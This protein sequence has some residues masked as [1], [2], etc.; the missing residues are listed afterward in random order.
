MKESVT[1]PVTDPAIQPLADVMRVVFC[2]TGTKA[3]PW[4]DG[5]R[6]LLPGADVNEWRPGAPPADYA[7]VWAPPAAPPL[8]HCQQQRRQQPTGQ[9][10]LFQ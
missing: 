3:K 6:T 8:L 9:L 7:I 1:E 5:L 2:C 4:L 10:L